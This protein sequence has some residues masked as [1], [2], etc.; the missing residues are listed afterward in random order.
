MQRQW[1]VVEGI[2]SGGTASESDAETLIKKEMP[3]A[4]VGYEEVA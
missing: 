4:V 2:F 1:D 3:E